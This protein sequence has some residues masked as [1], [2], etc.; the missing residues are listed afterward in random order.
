MGVQRMNNAFGGTFLQ[1]TNRPP[2]L[3][4]AGPPSGMRAQI[5]PAFTSQRPPFPPARVPNPNMQ[6]FRPLTNNNISSLPRPPVAPQNRLPQ[7]GG[8]N[9][10]S[11]P[12][13]HVSPGGHSQSTNMLTAPNNFS[14]T[15]NIPVRVPNS[16]NIFFG[17]NNQLLAGPRMPPRPNIPMQSFYAN[18]PPGVPVRP[19]TN[20]FS[21][22]MARPPPLQQHFPMQ[23]NSGF[24]NSYRQG[25]PHTS[26]LKSITPSSN[27][28]ARVNKEFNNTPTQT[29]AGNYKS[30]SE[31]ESGQYGDLSGCSSTRRRSRSGSESPET[32]KRLR[33]SRYASERTSSS[34]G[35]KSC[36][37]QDAPAPSSHL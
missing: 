13:R 34:D 12:V 14:S 19:Q 16:Q 31:R 36:F 22:Q 18:Q 27:P 4:N 32:N 10:N 15:Q 11:I 33:F 8:M 28:P 21:Q 2:P 20:A 9:Q 23:S 1:A 30:S 29:G 5:S 25:P 24:A 37:Q 7:P 3:R 26:N 6:S 35:I 17:K